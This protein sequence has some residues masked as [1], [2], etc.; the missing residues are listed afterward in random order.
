M[1]MPGSKVG[2]DQAFSKRLLT[3]AVLAPLAIVGIIWLP[4]QGLA[5]FL[6][7]LVLLGLW[8]WSRLIGFRRRRFRTTLLV[9]N[10]LL[11]TSAWL[12][13]PDAS[14]WW[15]VCI[16][17]V[18]W[19]LALVWLR[20][21]AFGQAATRR[22]LEI[23]VL[24]GSLVV[25][26]AWCAALLLHQ[27]VPHGPWW[28]LYV[29][30]MIWV[31]DIGAYFAG[32]NFGQR[33]LAP[34]ISPGKTREGAYGALIAVFFYAILG[35]WIFGFTGMNRVLLIALCLASAMFSIVGDLFESLMKRHSGNKDSGRIFP[36]HGGV[37]DRIDS[38][39]A[40]LPIFVFG[41]ILLGL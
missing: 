14:M 10:A 38:T 27:S 22:N 33:K 40:A 8:E 17:V 24:A 23:K 34:T 2:A 7:A 21:I 11:M 19:C 29:I 18:W 26:P 31:A 25:I 28:T 36:G 9:T 41:K 13:L 20:F 4:T 16:G 35:A 32:R 1:S 6:G 3:A 39:L 12:L 15:I 5:V 30:V 37:L